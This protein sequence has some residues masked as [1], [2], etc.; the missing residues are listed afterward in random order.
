MNIYIFD[1]DGVLADLRHRLHYKNRGDFDGFYEDKNVLADGLIQPG[2]ELLRIMNQDGIVVYATGRP[3]RTRQA[4]IEWLNNSRL[5]M[6]PMLMRK[7]GDFR[8]SPEIKVEQVR[9]AL[10]SFS[11]MFIADMDKVW[12]IDDDPKNVAAV[13]EAFPLKAKIKVNGLVYGTERF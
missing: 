5:P 2:R 8:P 7:D 4:T 1:I 13:E 6:R 3:E 10:E 12:F 9:E 11:N